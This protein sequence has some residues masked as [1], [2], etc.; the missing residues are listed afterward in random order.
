MGVT[1]S[2]A[3]VQDLEEIGDYIYADN[4]AAAVRFIA[5]LRNR[6]SRLSDAPR[7]GTARPELWVG[8]RSVTFRRYVVY[9]TVD[10]DEVRIERIRHGARDS[11]ILFTQDDDS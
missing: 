9:Y 2:P 8:L 6:C 10:G 5:E 3:S 1:F 4:P 7:S 11:S